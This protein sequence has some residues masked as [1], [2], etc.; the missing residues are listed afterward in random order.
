MLSDAGFE[1]HRGAGG[2]VQTVPVCGRAIEFERRVRLRQV[3]V[4][5]HLHRPVT[6]VDHLQ[7]E[8][9][10]ALIEPDIAVTE[11]DLTGVQCAPPP[12]MGSGGGR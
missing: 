9:L 5:A 10:R 7:R 4:A 3:Y 2:D 6:G 11:D 1:A 8:P 12:V